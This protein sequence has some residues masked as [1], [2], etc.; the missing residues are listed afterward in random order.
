MNKHITHFSK[1]IVLPLAILLAVT[2]CGNDNDDDD[3]NGGNNTEVLVGSNDGIIGT[4][5]V[6]I[7]GVYDNKTLRSVGNFDAYLFNNCYVTFG[8]GEKFTNHTSN[9]SL[10]W[11][12]SPSNENEF[13]IGQRIY[14]IVPQ[15]DGRTVISTTDSRYT[16]Y[17]LL[18]PSDVNQ[19]QVD[20]E[21]L[22]SDLGFVNPQTSY[23]GGTNLVD[24][25]LSVLWAD[26][27]MGGS[28]NDIRGQGGHYNLSQ[29]SIVW[30]N[31]QGTHNDEARYYYGGYWATPTKEEFEELLSKC[32]WTLTKYP[33]LSVDCYLVTGP[34][35]KTIYMPLGRYQSATQF[36]NI[37]KDAGFYTLDLTKTSRAIGQCKWTYLNNNK[38][39]DPKVN[40]FCIRAIEKIQ[41]SRIS[42]ATKVDLGIGTLWSGSNFGTSDPSEI[43]KFVHWADPTITRALNHMELLAGTESDVIRVY[44]GNHWR[45]PTYE[46]AVVLLSKCKWD[47][48]TLEGMPGYKI[49]GPNGNAIFLPAAGM[50]DY[51]NLRSSV[52]YVHY[53][54]ASKAESEYKQRFPGAVLYEGKVTMEWSDFWLPIRPV[55]N[56]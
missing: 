51:N 50:Y 8:K 41:L 23:S 11:T 22:L 45:I 26:M 39:E 24:L 20:N 53:W 56:D 6:T 4:W 38:Y 21:Q 12:F 15:V 7:D 47:Y 42:T 5:K 3:I 34:S 44:M 14:S 49:T 32:K 13:V 17:Y 31:L 54:L 52:G 10:R 35:G 46:E 30:Q 18:T 19:T 25:G 29:A 43:G 55:W 33:G 16:I 2:D 9:E 48:I 40:G 27:N 28:K 37:G 1:L 36:Y